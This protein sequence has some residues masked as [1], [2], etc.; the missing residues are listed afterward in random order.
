MELLYG[1]ALSKQDLDGIILAPEASVSN[2]FG[3]ET[4]PSIDTYESH[5]SH[6]QRSHRM[7][8]TVCRNPEFEAHL[9]ARTVLP[10]KDYLAEQRE[11]RKAAWKRGL[12]NL[13][14]REQEDQEIIKAVL[15]PDAK[16][17]N[18][19]C[20]SGQAM[21]FKDKMTSVM[22]EKLRATK[23]ATFTFSKEYFSS[24]RIPLISIAALLL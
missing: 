10:A 22:R 11:L 19:Y 23:N 7:E 13:A 12:E 2:D 3:I 4:M 15:G 9:H 8:A 24:V 21:N 1:D 20:Y 16:N 18:I 14:R 17:A 5:T 6:K